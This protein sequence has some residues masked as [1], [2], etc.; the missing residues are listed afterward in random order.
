[1]VSAFFELTIYYFLLGHRLIYE[2]N[3]LI[4]TAQ[5]KQAQA[6]QAMG[7]TTAP[8]SSKIPPITPPP[9]PPKESFVR[10]YK[11][12]WPLLITVNL[13]VGGPLDPQSFFNV[14]VSFCT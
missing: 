4:T 11:F 9:P 5:L 14:L 2:T 12:L 8:P 7:T 6:Q 1:M 10:R 13:A 3:D